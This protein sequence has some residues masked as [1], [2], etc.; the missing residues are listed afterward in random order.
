MDREELR[1]QVR[2]MVDGLFDEKEESEIRRK[3]EIALEKS[4][5]TISNLTSTLEEKV[6][7]IA[8]FETKVSEGIES[9]QS[10]EK[11][12]EAA[13]EELET[14]KALVIE[15][16]QVLEDMS[17]AK[18]ANERMVE[19]E[20]AGVARAEKEAQLVKIKEMSDEEFASYKEELVD[21]RKAVEAELEK[22]AK[23]SQT[24]K[25]GEDAKKAEEEK[26]EALAKSK[27]AENTEGNEEAD[28]TTTPAKITPGQAAMASLNMEFM[29]NEDL[30]AK[31]AKL[32]EALAEKWKDDSKE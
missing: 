26:A 15:K 21:V 24:K 32:G 13:R 17:K 12:L 19:L 4:A 25:A 8:E 1:T 23:D 29:P 18:V 20:S 10:L 16:E 27:A 5:E 11:E 30:M 28:E 2:A 14:S 31:Y 7:E 3:T 9:V 22:A 6:A